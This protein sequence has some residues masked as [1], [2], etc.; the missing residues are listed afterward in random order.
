MR[1]TGPGDVFTALD[2]LLVTVLLD[3]DC[4]QHSRISELRRENTRK[5]VRCA[6][7]TQTLG[8]I[9]PEMVQLLGIKANQDQD[10]GGHDRTVT[11][12]NSPTA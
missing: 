4:G 6:Y 10:A 1:V 2:E 7:K 5:L 8:N 11:V 12:S 9:D 3:P